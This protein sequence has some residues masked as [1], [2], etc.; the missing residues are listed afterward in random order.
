MNVLIIDFSNV[1]HRAFHAFKQLRTKK[2][3]HSGMPYGLL[4]LLHHYI[5]QN[6]ADIVF[7]ACDRFPRIR[8]LLY[9]A[10]KANR[11]KKDDNMRAVKN[12]QMAELEALVKNLNMFAVGVT[13]YEADDV[14]ATIA[15]H[16]R[17]DDVTIVSTDNDMLQL[18]PYC[19][20]IVQHKAKGKR[21]VITNNNFYDLK[22]IEN[23]YYLW[24][25]AMAGDSSDNI[26]GVRGVG[27]KT[28]ITFLNKF[29]PQT[30][31]NFDLLFQVRTSLTA[32][33]AIVLHKKE[34]ERNIKLIELKPIPE[35]T[36]VLL[37]ESTCS[38]NQKVFDDYLYKYELFSLHRLR[39]VFKY[40]HLRC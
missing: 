18:L 13:N 27:E 37:N 30:E 11:N 39:N 38:F 33:K 8:K 15:Y 14:I 23:K 36:K 21:I 3:E 22:G 4:F 1:A 29:L 26:Q 6:N 28:A 5:Q 25:K 34:I 10:Y 24:V 20:Q 35:I 7:C 16:Y 2:G 12:A 31:G 17:N 40:L 32:E 19:K 9:P